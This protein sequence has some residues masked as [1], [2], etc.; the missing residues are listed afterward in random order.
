MHVIAAV[1]HA[2]DTGTLN[3]RYD[4]HKTM[5]TGLIFREGRLM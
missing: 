1:E 3:C 4:L 2:F 5:L